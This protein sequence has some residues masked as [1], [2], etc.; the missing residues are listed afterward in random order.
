MSR[1]SFELLLISVITSIVV[2]QGERHYSN[3]IFATLQ[4]FTSVSNRIELAIWRGL[5]EKT[6]QVLCIL[7][8]F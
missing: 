3:E 1:L 2:K 4:L 7:V 6:F 5:T 8:Q